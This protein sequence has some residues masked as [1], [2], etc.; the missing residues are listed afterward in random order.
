VRGKRFVVVE[1]DEL[2]AEALGKALLGMGAK[3]KLFHRAEV[4]LNHSNIEDADYYI[5][6]YMLGGAL[7]GIEF[8]EQLR[9]KLNKP[10]HA[11]LMTGDTS[12]SFIRAAA[13]H[14]WPVVQ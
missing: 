5:V 11:V 1:D 2:V 10:V 7:N 4:A 3:V 13:T 8:L 6:D 14:D 9:Q 12:S